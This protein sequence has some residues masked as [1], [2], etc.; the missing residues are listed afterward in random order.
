MIINY[1]YYC[2][3][4]DYCYQFAGFDADESGVRRQLAAS[5]LYDAV[6]H[7]LLIRKPHLRLDR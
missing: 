5:V 3:N 1:Y 6:L 7:G 4:D 2:Y